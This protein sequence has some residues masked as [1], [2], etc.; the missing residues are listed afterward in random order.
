MIDDF[1]TIFVGSRSPTLHKY[2]NLTCDACQ[3]GELQL[4]ASVPN[5]P[6]PELD[7]WGNEFVFVLFWLCPS[8]KAITA[9]NECD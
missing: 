6:I 3:E 8:C 1:S 5:N 7:I 9:H 4:L 2:D